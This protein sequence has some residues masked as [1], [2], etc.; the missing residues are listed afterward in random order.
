MTPEER[1]DE[2]I[3]RVLMAGGMVSLKWCRRPKLDKMRQAMRDIMSESYIA[4][5]NA[6]HKAM[7]EDES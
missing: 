4:G 6:C 2:A 5:S 1:I 3:D 7:K